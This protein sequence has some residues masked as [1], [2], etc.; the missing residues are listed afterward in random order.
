MRPNPSATELLQ[1]RKQ[2]FQRRIVAERAADVDIAVHIA[3]PENEAAAKLKRILSYLMLPVSARARTLTGGLVLAPQ[4]MQQVRIAQ[5]GR[6]IGLALLVDQ[7]RK[8]NARILTEQACVVC[9]AQ[10]NGRQ[11]GAPLTECLLVFAQLRDVL[12]AEDSTIVAQKDDYCG[13]PLPKRSQPDF[14][15]IRIGKDDGC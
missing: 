4:Q 3:W 11:V 7:Q 8:C 5:T 15:P 6:A 13:L 1:H 2:I 9:V 14:A 12:A 10:A